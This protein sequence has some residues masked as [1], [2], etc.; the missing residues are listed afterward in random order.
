MLSGHCLLNFGE[1]GSISIRYIM[2]LV[3]SSFLVCCFIMLVR[4]IAVLN[5]IVIGVKLVKLSNLDVLVCISCSKNVGAIL[6]I[7]MNCLVGEL[8]SMMVVMLLGKGTFGSGLWSRSK[9]IMGFCFCGVLFSEED[10]GL[11]V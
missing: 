7:L 3:G 8:G 5:E 2:L 9:I 4:F 6:F 10:G 11:F 1:F